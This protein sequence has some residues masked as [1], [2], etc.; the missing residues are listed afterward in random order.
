MIPAVGQGYVVEGDII[1]NMVCVRFEA[2][3]TS[4]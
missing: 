4:G 1:P 2:G 3:L